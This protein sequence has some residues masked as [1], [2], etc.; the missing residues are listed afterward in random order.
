MSLHL[1]EFKLVDSQLN[2]LNYISNPFPFSSCQRR[3]KIFK[4]KINLY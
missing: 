2:H 4:S 3:H 1:S